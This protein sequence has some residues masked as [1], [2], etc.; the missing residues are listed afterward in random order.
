MK[1]LFKYI[2][3]ILI[4]VFCF[5]AF[6]NLGKKKDNVGSSITNVENQVDFSKITYTALG[7]SITEASGKIA[8]ST[9][10]KEIL[11]LK[12]AFNKGIGGTTISNVHNGMIDRYTEISIYSDIISIQGGI[13]DCRLNAD[14]GTIDS[15]DKSTFMGAYN[16]LI[17]GVKEKYYRPAPK[18]LAA[19]MLTFMPV[20]GLNLSVGSSII[21]GTG[22]MWAAFSLPISFF[23]SIDHQMNFNTADNENTQIFLNIS[24]RNLKYTHFYASVFVDEFSF[25]RLKK[26]SNQFNFLGWKIGGRVSNWPVKNLSAVVEYTQTNPATYEHLYDILKYT[27]NQSNCN[28][29]FYLR[30][31]MKNF[32]TYYITS[33]DSFFLNSLYVIYKY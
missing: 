25:G 10:V 9:R 7:D 12:K 24:T 3:I 8:Y 23:N 20:K 31:T 2:I 29:L 26:S 16:S 5:G 33:N 15:Y 32:K 17:K 1:N 30:F 28:H 6:V 22:T 21:Y 27:S 11:G 13:N 19:N 14:L 4:F 18:Y